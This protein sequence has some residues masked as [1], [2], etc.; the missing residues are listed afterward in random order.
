[1][2]HG[3]LA[4]NGEDDVIAGDVEFSVRYEILRAFEAH[5]ETVAEISGRDPKV[6]FRKKGDV[7]RLV[8]TVSAV[9]AVSPQDVK[10]MSALDFGRL[11]KLVRALL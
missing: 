3:D 7:S 1:M 5:C 4:R 2:S 11:A 9:S 8:R 6:A 10:A